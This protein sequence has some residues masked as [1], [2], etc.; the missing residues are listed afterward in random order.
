MGCTFR[1]TQTLKAAREGDGTCVCRGGGPS[2]ETPL[3]ELR[4][5]RER[6]LALRK[7][8]REMGT[9]SCSPSRGELGPEHGR[10]PQGPCP[11]VG[12]RNPS[13]PSFLPIFAESF[14][15][16]HAPRASGG[17]VQRLESNIVPNGAAHCIHLQMSPKTLSHLSRIKSTEPC[18]DLSAEEGTR[19]LKE[20]RYRTSPVSWSRALCPPA[21]WRVACLNFCGCPAG[22]VRGM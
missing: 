15:P 4:L 19:I 6:L 18:R 8:Q 11:S 20:H 5:W 16:T 1:T 17:L 3:E 21:T 7:R 9:L 12:P 2:T 22:Y 10:W 14:H 13:V